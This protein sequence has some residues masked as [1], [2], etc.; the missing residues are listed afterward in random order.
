[1]VDFTHI[2]C[3]KFQNPRLRNEE[4][5]PGD[6]KLLPQIYKLTEDPRVLMKLS[7]KVNFILEKITCDMISQLNNVIFLLS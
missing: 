5:S 7:E 1:M 2:L 6:E 3:A 4:I